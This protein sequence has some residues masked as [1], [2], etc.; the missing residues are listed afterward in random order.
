MVNK[1]I[2]YVE[3]LKHKKNIRSYLEDLF[4]KFPDTKLFLPIDLTK[5]ERHMIYKNSKGY[6]FEKLHNIS[7]FYSISIYK[8]DKC[9]NTDNYLDENTDNYLDENTDNYLD[10]NTDSE[11]DFNLNDVVEELNDLNKN[12]KHLSRLIKLIV[13]L[14]LVTWSYFIAADP[15]RL[16]VENIMNQCS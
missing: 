3:F 16:I 13:L 4:Q 8:E 15:A 2:S 7:N 9:V 5:E 1:C 14:N 12:V 11:E 6:I 10:E